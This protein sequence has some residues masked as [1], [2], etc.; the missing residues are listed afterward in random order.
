MSALNIHLQK[1][2][3]GYEELHSQVKDKLASILGD[4]DDYLPRYRASVK[5]SHVLHVAGTL[6]KTKDELESSLHYLGESVCMRLSS[7]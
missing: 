3:P 2:D 5:C 7:P 1:A 6:N 4:F